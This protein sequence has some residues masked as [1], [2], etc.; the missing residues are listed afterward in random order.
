MPRPRNAS[1]TQA[2]ILAAARVRFGADGYERTTLRTV[3][4]DVG[5]HPAL[6]IR[7]FG[8]KEGLFAAAIDFAVDLPDLTGVEPDDLAEHLLPR[9]FEVWEDNGAFLSL[10]RS[11][12]TSP[13]AAAKMREIFATQVSPVFKAITPDHPTERA[14]LLGS[15]VIGLATSRYILKTPGITELDHDDLTR[16][17][18]PV[19]QHILTGPVPAPTREIS[20]APRSGRRS[21]D[22]DESR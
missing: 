13:T 18:A 10:L 1:A 20:S 14:G 16:W 3:A 8:D 2:D 15:F 7:Y 4:A 22:G 21:A 5:V 6:V 11:A 12:A 17:A 19:M 9:F